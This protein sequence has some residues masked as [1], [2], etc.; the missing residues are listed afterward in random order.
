MHYRRNN[1]ISALKKQIS[2]ETK[3]IFHGCLTK[4]IYNFAKN[5]EGALLNTLKKDS[6]KIKIYVDFKVLH[7]ENNILKKYQHL[8]E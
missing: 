7:K 1:H 3:C 5:V 4:L 6:I 2:T 8:F